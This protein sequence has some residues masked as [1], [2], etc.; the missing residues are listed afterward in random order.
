MAVAEA[1]LAPIAST[2]I[3]RVPMRARRSG[4]MKDPEVE[5][6]TRDMR[7]GTNPTAKARPDRAPALSPSYYERY[8]RESRHECSKGPTMS[9]WEAT[10]GVCVGAIQELDA[11]AAIWETATAAARR[12]TLVAP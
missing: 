7:G 10:N 2:P 6:A 11:R 9:P 5:C 8:R 1:V 12:A 4:N 3:A